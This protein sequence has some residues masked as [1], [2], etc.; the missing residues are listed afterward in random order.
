MWQPVNRYYAFEDVDMVRL[1]DR[2][3]KCLLAAKTERCILRLLSLNEQMSRIY[4]DMT[5]WSEAAYKAQ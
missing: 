2:L 3:P 1:R 4:G 5:E